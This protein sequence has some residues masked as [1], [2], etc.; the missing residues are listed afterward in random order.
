MGFYFLP[1]Q[2]NLTFDSENDNGL[3]CC[4]IEII[5]VF[6]AQLILAFL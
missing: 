5:L 2:A 4:K 3:F 1:G 6:P